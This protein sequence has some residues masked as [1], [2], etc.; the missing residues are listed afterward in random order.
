MK[1]ET[2]LNAI[3]SVQFIIE[4]FQFSILA[5]YLGNF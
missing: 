1:N 5:C 2:F 4:R 3:I